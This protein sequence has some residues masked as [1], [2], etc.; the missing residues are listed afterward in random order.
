MVHVWVVSYDLDLTYQLL[1]YNTVLVFLIMLLRCPLAF[2]TE[3]ISRVVI[4][5]AILES[6]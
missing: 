6:T 2:V 5:C 1:K 4:L 3:L